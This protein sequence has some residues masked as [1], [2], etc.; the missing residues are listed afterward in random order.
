MNRRDIIKAGM[1]SVALTMVPNAMLKASGISEHYMP[2]LE[3]AYTTLV[4][5]GH[6]KQDNLFLW[7]VMTVKNEI[8]F[9]EN[10]NSILSKYS[11]RSS[12][13]YSSTDR[14]EIAP[15]KQI[16]DFL[17]KEGGVTFDSTVF[18]GDPKKF[19]N[20]APLAL[21]LK[22]EELYKKCSRNNQ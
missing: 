11:Y 19:R 4:K 9:L 7:S 14:F 13:K 2:I 15:A 12:I 10:I 1:S 20:V 16:I 18:N 6:P 8:G 21:N 22:M 17:L 5:H 3:G